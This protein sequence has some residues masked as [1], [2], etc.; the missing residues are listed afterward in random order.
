LVAL[1]KIM[2]GKLTRAF[3]PIAGLHHARRDEA[4]GFCIFNDCAIAIEILRQVYGVRRVAYVDI[5]AHHGDGVFYAFEDDPDVIFADIHEDGRFLYPHTGDASETGRGRARGTKLNIPLPPGADDTLFFEAWTNVEEL[6]DRFIP[7]IILMQAGADS[8][9][10]DPL[11][12]LGLTAAA[13]AHATRRLVVL[14]DRHCRGKLLVTGGGGYDR[15]NLREAWTA[16]T[17][18]LLSR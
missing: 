1:A 16:V 15:Q 9:A 13:H 12:H 18:E 6:I 4:A 14:A 5:D 10:G 3:V 11:T 8:L 2:E 17:S 7:E